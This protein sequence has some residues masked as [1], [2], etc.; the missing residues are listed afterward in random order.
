MHDSVEDDVVLDD[1]NV[2]ED[3]DVVVDFELE[4]IVVE[5]VCEDVDTEGHRPHSC[6]Q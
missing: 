1:V 5:V 4:E 2:L 3:A 6:G